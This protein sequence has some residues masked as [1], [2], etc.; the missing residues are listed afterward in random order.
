MRFEKF[1]LGSIRID[2]TTYDH[3]VVIDRGEVRKRKK[4]PSQEFRD[5]FGHTPVSPNEAIP[6]KCRLVIGTGNGALH[7]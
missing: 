6:W 5:A 3:D 7:L 4:K 2:G 1:S